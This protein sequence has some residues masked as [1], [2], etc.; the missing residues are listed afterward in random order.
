MNQLIAVT[1]G[2]LRNTQQGIKVDRSSVLGNPFKMRHEG[3]RDAVCD[4]YEHYFEKVLAEG[5]PIKV[6]NQ[7]AQERAL[8]I[9]DV[10]KRPT[11]QQFIA[12]LDRV[13]GALRKNPKQPVLCWCAKARCHGETL[14]RH[15]ERALNKTPINQVAEGTLSHAF[16]AIQPAPNRI[17]QL[18]PHQVFVFGSNTEGRH[19]KGAALI[20]SKFGAEYGNSSGRQGQTYAIVTKDLKQGERSIPLFEI[21]AQVEMFLEHAQ[22][23]PQ[24]EFLIMKIGCALAGYSETEI[25]SLWVGKDIPGNV[26]LPQAFLDVIQQS[27]KGE[28]QVGSREI[29][30]VDKV[31]ENPLANPQSLNNTAAVPEIVKDKEQAQA[32]RT[33]LEIDSGGQTGADLGSLIG[34]QA[35]G[36][37]TGGVAPHGWLV[38]QD[39]RFPNRT[40]PGLADFGLVE[41][42][43]GNSEGHT[44]II[45]TEMNVKATDG[46]AILGSAD[47]NRDKGSARTI[48]LADKHGK[49]W[50]HFELDELN[51]P[52]QC[53][54]ELRAWVIDNNVRKLNVAGNR[55]SKAPQLEGQTAQIIEG[56][57]REPIQWQQKVVNYLCRVDPEVVFSP[58]E[59]A[60]ARMETAKIVEGAIKTAAENGY[61][62][63]VFRVSTLTGNNG[64]LQEAIDRAQER[65]RDGNLPPIEV[66]LTTDRVTGKSGKDDAFI[67]VTTGRDERTTQAIAVSRQA[68]VQVFGF[69][70]ARNVALKVNTLP[71]LKKPQSER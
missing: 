6:A 30:K 55:G 31:M 50:I 7:V 47:P 29:K 68:G 18:E 32:V 64:L 67:A 26:R 40:N 51:N 65:Q 49:P 24:N 66:A 44:Y 39:V 10:W 17:T 38:E 70:V 15:W 12:E 4:G 63:A 61:D 36:I 11:Q 16:N 59:Q 60:I 37:P 8:E 9:T 35:V 62:R 41:G 45:R 57:F 33:D 2:N 13:E 42:P 54:Q 52:Q 22:A 58:R 28:A 53:A 3:E 48:E 46:T 56:A 43:K 69:D 27:E 23:H 1:V 5:E 71:A 21:E 25:G 19:G 14:A 34:A 20:A